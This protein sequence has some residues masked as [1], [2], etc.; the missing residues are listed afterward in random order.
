MAKARE[1]IKNTEMPLLMVVSEHD[2]VVSNKAIEENFK[3]SKSPDSKILRLNGVDHSNVLYDPPILSLLVRE[4]IS[5]F[6]NR[7]N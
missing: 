5:F 6:N 3:L 2:D 1:V 7:I 4:T